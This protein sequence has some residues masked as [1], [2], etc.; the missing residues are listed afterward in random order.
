MKLRTE[1]KVLDRLDWEIGWRRKEIDG[2]KTVVR[3]ESNDF[4]SNTL[5]RAGIPLIYAHWEGFVKAGVEAILCFVSLSG[6]KYQELAPYFAVLGVKKK[7]DEFT[8]PEKIQIRIEAMKFL[9]NEMENEAN[10]NWKG[11]IDTGSNLT[12]DR[13]SDIAEA[14]GVNVSHYETRKKFIDQ[15]LVERRN[16]IAHGHKVDLAIDGF[17]DVADQVQVLLQRFKTDLENCISNKSYL[18]P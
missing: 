4:I 17:M 15:S 8:K 5:I 18:R 1:D 2:M 16:L 6:K 10:F 3:R 7:L 9:M 14:I 13:F 11:Q 12:F